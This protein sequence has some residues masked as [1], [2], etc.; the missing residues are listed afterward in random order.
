MVSA[1]TKI[2]PTQA[3]PT[4]VRNTQRD[5]SRTLVA[6]GNPRPSLLCAGR[7]AGGR[8]RERSG[9]AGGFSKMDFIKLGR[10]AP[11]LNKLRDFSALS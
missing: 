11:P 6:W 9:S 5:P 7:E 1:A 4:K 10:L 3:T 8:V 2:P